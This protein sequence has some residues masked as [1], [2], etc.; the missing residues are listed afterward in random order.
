MTRQMFGE[1]VSV[2]PM[3]Q[4]EM[5]AVSDPDRTVMLDLPIYF[6]AAPD[7]EQLGGGRE[8]ASAAYAAGVSHS[9]SVET[10]ALAYP[11]RDGDILVRAAAKGGKQYRI[12]HVKPIDQ[13]RTLLLLSESA[14]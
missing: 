13:S 5:K 12:V 14:A 2:R 11:P 10:G 9:A 3:R 4:G 7:V 6:D 8:R 1:L